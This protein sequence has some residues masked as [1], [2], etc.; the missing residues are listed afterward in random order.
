MRFISIFLHS[1]GHHKKIW[2]ISVMPM[3]S[4]LF[5]GVCVFFP[6]FSHKTLMISFSVMFLLLFVVFQI[7]LSRTFHA[8]FQ[9]LT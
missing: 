9:S 8:Q 1:M 4:I 5:M 7:S 6:E 2:M 3:I